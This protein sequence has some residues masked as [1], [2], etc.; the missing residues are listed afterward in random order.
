M[1][2]TYPALRGFETS[3][4][5]E[6]ISISTS[7]HAIVGRTL[8]GKYRVERLIGRGGMGAVFLATHEGTGRPVA[9]K[10]ILPQIVEDLE[11]IERFRREARAAGQRGGRGDRGGGADAAVRIVRR[12]A[13]P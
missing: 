5:V 10:L 8:D 12:A 6:P 9:V 7:E 3:S 13:G 1:A 2:S 11:A 4:R